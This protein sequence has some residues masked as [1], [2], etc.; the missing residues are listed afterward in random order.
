MMIPHHLKTGAKRT[1]YEA[2]ITQPAVVS[3]KPTLYTPKQ[4]MQQQN[5]LSNSVDFLALQSEVEKKLK[6]LK[7]KVS[8]PAELAI[9]QG[10]H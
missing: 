10:T 5:V 3:A 9:S 2:F 4:V 8:V 1:G 7:E 6:K